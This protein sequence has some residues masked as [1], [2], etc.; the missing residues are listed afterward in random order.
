MTTRTVWI[1]VIVGSLLAGA[2]LWS[3][4]DVNLPGNDQGYAPEQPIH[5]SHRLHAGEMNIDCAYC[6]TGVEK[7]RH[8]GIPALGVCMNCHRFVKAPIAQVRA[9]AV[10]AKAEG[11][12]PRTIRSPQIQKIYDALGLKGDLAAAPAK[13]AKG[14]EWVKVHDLPDFVYFDHS[15]HVNSGV[16]CDT[17]HGPVHTMERVRQVSDLSMGFC[18][19]CHRDVNE[20]GLNGD[21]SL[22]ASTDCAACHY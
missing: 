7:S 11:R 4:A 3:A 1:L 9:E 6:H 22:H 18:V 15:R 5:F 16:A 17:C 20:N 13:D 8:A 2:A 14:I 10:K 21:H 19:N 12:A